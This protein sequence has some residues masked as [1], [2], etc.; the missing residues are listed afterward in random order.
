MPY[1]FNFEKGNKRP[2]KYKLSKEEKK[3][4][5]EWEFLQDLRLKK[6]K[7]DE[8]QQFLSSSDANS[9]K[10]IIPNE[11]NPLKAGKMNKGGNQWAKYPKMQI[12]RKDDSHFENPALIIDDER[13]DDSRPSNMK[14]KNFRKRHEQHEMNMTHNNHEYLDNMSR[15]EESMVAFSDAAMLKSASQVPVNHNMQNPNYLYEEQEGSIDLRSEYS[16][17]SKNAPKS[18]KQ[19]N[20]NMINN[21]ISNLNKKSNDDNKAFCEYKDISSWRDVY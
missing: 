19:E 14:G 20:N 7:D 9:A 15:G 4:L 17:Y 13:V 10:F 1:G 8:M 18:G 6:I 16:F 2:K 21:N 5:K 11:Y 3:R 12:D